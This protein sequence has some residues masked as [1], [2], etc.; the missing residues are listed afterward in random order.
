MQTR[1]NFLKSVSTSGLV[2]FGTQAAVES[3]ELAT[4]GDRRQSY[5]VPLRDGWEFRLDPG[6]STDALAL[7]E[8]AAGRN[9]DL[10]VMGGYGH[11]RLR[12]FIWG[13]VTRNM[14][15]AMTVPCL[16]SH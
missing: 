16:M 12:E 7:L 11:S 3:E 1:R 6:A 8:A 10:I 9:A 15:S 2:L 13:G 5:S 14:L 4:S